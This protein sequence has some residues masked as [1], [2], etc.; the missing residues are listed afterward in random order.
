MMDSGAPQWYVDGQME[1]FQ[2][3]LKGFQARVTN[4]VSE[5]A[6]KK[7]TSFDQFVRDHAASFRN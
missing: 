4:V 2:V 3:R 6:K 5:V 7:P 1:Q